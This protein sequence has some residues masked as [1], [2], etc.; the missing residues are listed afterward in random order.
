MERIRSSGDIEKRALCGICAAGCWV[1]V[2]YDSDGKIKS[3]RADETSS[4][5]AICRAGECSREIVYSKDRLLYPMKR[6]GPKG[7]YDFE[8]ISWD[9]AYEIIIARLNSIKDESG[10][11]ATAIYTGSGSF[12]RSLCDIYQPKGVAVS[13][14]SSVLFPFGSPNTLG[15]GALCYVSFAMIAPH[16]TMGGMF[17]NMFSDIENANLI[18]IWGKNPAAHCPPDDFIRIQEAHRRGARIVVIDPRKTAM[19]CRGKS[20]FSLH[21]I[22]PRGIHVPLSQPRPTHTTQ[23]SSPTV[24]GRFGT[25]GA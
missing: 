24:A 18:V 23:I 16:V 11:E 8:Q 21:R 10:A 14:A 20:T 13:S 1:I 5:G 19:A 7:T 22:R 4:L 12:E 17:I 15:V 2:T 3:V 25:G 9:E 6:K